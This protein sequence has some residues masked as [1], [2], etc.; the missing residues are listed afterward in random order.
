MSVNSRSS[1]QSKETLTDFLKPAVTERI[2]EDI[3]THPVEECTSREVLKRLGYHAQNMAGRN[4][5]R[6][7]EMAGLGI[8]VEHPGNKRGVPATYEISPLAAEELAN[9]CEA[10]II[11]ICGV[12]DALKERYP[13]IAERYE[14]IAD[15][16]PTIPDEVGP[17]A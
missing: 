5:L 3:A 12:L 1:G 14:G 17:E 13:M 2:I 16:P 15:F 7:R 6:F 10:Q 4:W 9:H 8:L 11:A